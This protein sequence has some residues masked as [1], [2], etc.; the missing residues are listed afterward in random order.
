MSLFYDHECEI[1]FGGFFSEHGPNGATQGKKME[2]PPELRIATLH[3]LG[4]HL[5]VILTFSSESIPTGLRLVMLYHL[6]AVV[7]IMASV[8]YVSTPFLT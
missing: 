3:D 2:F 4:K 8:M 7:L 1:L 6:H 5:P